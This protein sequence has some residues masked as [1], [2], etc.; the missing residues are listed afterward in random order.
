[1]IDSLEELKPML[2]GLLKKIN[3]EE[4]G[5]QDAK[6]LSEHFNIAIEALKKQI[7]QTKLFDNVDTYLCSNCEEEVEDNEYCSSCGQHLK[8]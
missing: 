3:Y 5:E 2:G 4:L 7:P 6:E 1:V 8:L